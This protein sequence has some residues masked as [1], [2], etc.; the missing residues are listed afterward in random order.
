M[1]KS[2]TVL[3]MIVA[4]L[5]GHWETTALSVRQGR[6]RSLCM[7]NDSVIQLSPALKFVCGAWS[8]RDQSC[9]FCTPCL[10]VFPTHF[11][12]LDLNPANSEATVEEKW[13]SEFLF[14]RKQH[15]SMTSQLRH[16][17]VVPCKYWW[18]I[19]QFF[20][21]TICQDD[22]C[23]KLWKVVWICQSYSQNTVSPFSR[24]WCMYKNTR[25]HDHMKNTS[26][27]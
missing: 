1:S 23:Q 21:H 20:N 13:T 26:Y 22:S 15:F 18:D 17:Y 16:H 6:R 10:A 2:K 14:L 7:H 5:D 8:R 19:L 24:T 4:G 3:E 12:Q 9:M 27:N 25:M 11:S